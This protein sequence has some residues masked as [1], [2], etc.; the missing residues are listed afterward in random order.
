MELGTADA[1]SKT[2]D[3]NT[4]TP[5]KHV[6]VVVNPYKK[7]RVENDGHVESDDK[8]SL[9]TL[10][11][12]LDTFS[13][14]NMT[15]LVCKVIGYGT[16]CV[17][18]TKKEHYVISKNAEAWRKHCRDEAKDMP[19]NIFCF[20][21]GCY[22]PAAICKSLTRREGKKSHYYISTSG[23]QCQYPDI[24]LDVVYILTYLNGRDAKK[25]LVDA[26]GGN[27]KLHTLL[28]TIYEMDGEKYILLHRVFLELCKK[29]AMKPALLTNNTTK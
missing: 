12:F 16:D 2:G 9:V 18:E 28:T 29:F 25:Q 5:S 6:A 3:L 11:E 22:V 19:N 24:L 21:P 14:K 23:K 27:K 8:L 26:I 1:K 15:C 4:V 10:K 20:Q 17:N 13:C 7:Q